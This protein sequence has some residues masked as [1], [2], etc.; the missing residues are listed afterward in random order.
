[1]RDYTVLNDYN[2][3]IEVH[4]YVTYGAAGLLNRLHIEKRY[5]QINSY[6]ALKPG[7]KIE[8]HADN[9]WSAKFFLQKSTT[10]EKLKFSDLFHTYC[11]S[12]EDYVSLL[13]TLQP[14]GITGVLS[15]MRRWLPQ[16][17]TIGFP[18]RFYEVKDYHSNLIPRFNFNLEMI[19]WTGNTSKLSGKNN[20][21]G[22]AK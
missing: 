5:R 17:E 11:W 9:T 19:K 15:T 22:A 7:Y 12:F 14:Q 21:R 4:G 10:V 20:A 3:A 6:V 2:Q 18:Y 8:K 16:I 13:A 1:M